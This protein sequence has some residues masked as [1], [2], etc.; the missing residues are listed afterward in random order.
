[1]ADSC[2]DLLGVEDVLDE[3]ERLGLDPQ[4]VRIYLATRQHDGV[5]V[6]GRGLVERLIDL[7]RSPPI[8]LVPTLDLAT[9]QG[10]HIDGRTGLLKTVPRHLEFGLLETI[11]SE[12][13]DF[14]ALQIH[15]F[16]P[17]YLRSQIIGSREHRSLRV[18]ARPDGATVGA[19]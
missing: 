2:H 17:P 9:R 19:T 13:R 11:G 6:A 18:S 4:Q 8:L 3:L 5:V 10:D 15:R 12:N 16:H 7:D 1:M 14:F